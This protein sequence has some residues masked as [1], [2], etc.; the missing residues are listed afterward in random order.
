MSVYDLCFLLI[1]SV[2]E[3]KISCYGCNCGNGVCI[4]IFI[5][6]VVYFMILLKL[7]SIYVDFDFWY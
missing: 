5:D 7:K 2:R 1:V 3:S 6:D 4:L